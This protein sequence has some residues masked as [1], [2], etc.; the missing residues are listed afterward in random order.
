LDKFWNKLSECTG[1]NY[2]DLSDCLLV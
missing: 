2:E 1:I